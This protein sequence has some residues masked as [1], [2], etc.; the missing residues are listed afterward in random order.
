MYIHITPSANTSRSAIGIINMLR[1]D[2]DVRKRTIME[3]F[4]NGSNDW[5]VKIAYDDDAIGEIIKARLELHRDTYSE[6]DINDNGEW[7]L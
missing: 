5:R 6:Y 2:I 7:T 1:K 4:V 3:V